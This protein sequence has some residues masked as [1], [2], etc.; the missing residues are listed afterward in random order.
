MAIPFCVLVPNWIKKTLKMC[1]SGSCPWQR[2]GDRLRQNCSTGGG[3]GV[4]CVPAT[5]LVDLNV[6]L[7]GPGSRR[8]CLWGRKKQQ[9]AWQE[10]VFS[11]VPEEGQAQGWCRRVE[12]HMGH[13]RLKGGAQGGPVEHTREKEVRVVPKGK[14]WWRGKKQKNT[15]KPFETSVKKKVKNF[16]TPTQARI[17]RPAEPRRH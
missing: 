13:T 17:D 11:N 2:N 4:G 8:Q 12:R 5:R 14:K 16:L 10:Q 9:I 15:K 6:V 3:G 7:G 1:G